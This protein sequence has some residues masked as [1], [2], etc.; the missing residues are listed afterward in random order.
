MQL[1][2]HCTTVTVVVCCTSYCL[3]LRCCCAV[4][5]L[6]RGGVVTVQYCCGWL[7]LATMGTR[8]Y[9]FDFMK[10]SH[11]EQRLPAGGVCIVF[12]LSGLR[13]SCRCTS[14]NVAI[15]NTASYEEGYSMKGKLCALLCCLWCRFPCPTRVGLRGEARSLRQHVGQYFIDENHQLYFGRREL[16]TPP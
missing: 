1:L 5:L 13:V 10:S 2:L 9:G 6:G 7:G 16:R 15:R 12:V 11:H 8:D 4:L 3:L 14:C